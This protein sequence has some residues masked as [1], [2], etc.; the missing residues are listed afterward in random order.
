[1]VRATLAGRATRAAALLALVLPIGPTASAKADD[2]AVTPAPTAAQQEQLRQRD[3]LGEQAQRLLDE[4]KPAEV[5][6]GI[7]HR[8]R[9][10]ANVEVR[11]TLEWPAGLYEASDDWMAWTSGGNPSDLLRPESSAE[12]EEIPQ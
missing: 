8:E 7:E 4:G 3:H 9:G 1:M 12:P 10:R 5:K 2:P 6:L 11:A